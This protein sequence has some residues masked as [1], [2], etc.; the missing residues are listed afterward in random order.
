MP[1]PVDR[2][3]GCRILA[4]AALSAGCQGEQSSLAPAGP[5]AER[6]AEMGWLMLAG[7]SAILLLVTAM[8]A[9][10]AYAPDQARWL[11]HRRTVIAGGLAFPAIVLTALLLYEFA[12]ASG[13]AQDARRQTPLR[14]EAVGEQWWWRVRYPGDGEAATSAN[15]IHLPVGRLVEFVL[16]SP[17]VIHSF[18]IPPLGGKL[19]MIP[20]RENVLVLEASKPG[21]YRG[22]CAEFCG[23]Q[24]ARMAFHVVV[25]APDE[26]SQ[27]LERERR[28]AR[29]PDEPQLTKGRDLFINYGCGGCHAIRGTDAIGEMGPDLTP[30]ASRRS[31]GAG[32]LPNDRETMIAWIA[33]S[34]RLKPGNLMPPFDTIPRGELEAIAAYLGSLK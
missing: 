23:L 12:S 9:Y 34:Q 28:P 33:D 18:W 1:G 7:A 3:S 13:L 10:A 24:H 5:Q 31:L 14:I 29:E 30:V 19:D 4:L 8:T 27:W 16:T 6:V 15:E 32:I 26:F 17:N 21:T 11:G 22:Q 2:P 20:G 25:H